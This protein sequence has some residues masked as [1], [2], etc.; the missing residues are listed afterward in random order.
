MSKIFY[1]GG[2]M[3]FEEKLTW[4]STLILLA[5]FGIYWAIILGRAQG[6][7]ITDV[8]YA[9][10]MLWSLGA[11]VIGSVVGA[12]LA[13]IATPKEADKKDQRDRDIKRH[14]DAVGGNVLALGILVPLC[15]TM[16]KIPHFWIAHSIYLCC[17]VAGLWGS[18]V[19]I[20]AYRRGF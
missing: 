15:L 19:K 13:A 17:V 11:V 18:I 10:A 3:S 16:A 1:I 2:E 6:I 20:I 4:I 8:P 5:S 14:G 12:V 7:P 9:G